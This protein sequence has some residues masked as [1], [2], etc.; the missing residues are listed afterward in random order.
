MYYTGAIRNQKK[1]VCCTLSTTG[2]TSMSA[3]TTRILSNLLSIQIGPDRNPTAKK[4]GTYFQ[5]IK[6]FMKWPT[7]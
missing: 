6:K 1:Q 5:L 3:A 4:K 2:H 7:A